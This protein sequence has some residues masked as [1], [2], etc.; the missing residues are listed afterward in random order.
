[1]WFALTLALGLALLAVAQQAVYQQCGGIGWTGGT[2]C[3]SGSVCTV[4]N[5]YYSQCLPG[6]APPSSSSSTLPASSSSSPTSTSPTS[7]TSGSAPSS[8]PPANLSPAWQA[9]YT[10]ARAKLTGVSLQD[11][12]SLATGVGWMNG[13]NAASASTKTYPYLDSPRKLR[14]EYSKYFVHKLPWLVSTSPLGVRFGDLVSVFPAGINTAATFNRTLMRQRGAALGTEFHGKGVHVALGPAMNLARAPAAGRNWEG[15]GGDPYLSGEGAFETVTGI[16]SVGVQACAKHLINNEQEHFR[17]TSSSNVDDRTQHE[18]YA[19]PFLRSI[20]AGVASVMCS[21]INGSFACENDKVLNG[22]I[23]GEF[24]FPGYI[25]SDWAATHSTGSV[26]QGLDMTMPGDITFSSGTTYFGQNLVNA[27]QSGSVPQS[28][29]DDMATRI[30]AAWY[31]LGQDSGYPAVNFNSWNVNGPGSTHVNVQGNHK[32][33]IRTIG[34]ASTVLLKNTGK[35]LPLNKPRT[36]GIIGNGA[37][38]GSG[39]A[40]Y[41]YLI[42]PL[43]AI[44]S[45]ASTDGSTVSSSLSD[46]DLNAAGTTATGKDVALVF[47]AA[48]SGEGYITVEGNAG[49]RNDLKAWHSG[50]ALVARVAGANANTIVV[51]NSVGP[52]EVEAWINHPNVTAVVWS[53]LPGQEAGNALVDVLYGAYNPSGRLPYT[54]GKSINDYSAKVIYNSNA[55]ILPIPYSEGLFIDYRHFDQANIAPRFEFGFGLSY[56]TFSYASLS[57][58]GSIGTG[59]APTGPG[60]SLDPWL[61]EK[62]IT[63]TFSLTNSGSVAGHEIPQLYITLPASAQSAPLSLKG[64]DSIFLAPNQS[65]TVTIQLSRFDLSIWNVAAQRWQI[66]SG[67]IGVSVG[68]SSR[69]IRLTGTI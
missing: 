50:D 45:R 44:T 38:W 68:A 6:T 47:I 31:L 3:A 49:D 28:R 52:I 33:L 56:T 26:N 7:T 57:I 41:P 24:G 25:M 63:V 51:V 32:D 42:T 34:A 65:K 1:M 46:T 13:E 19:L 29:I 5:D 37:G 58:S 16:Q 36:I 48:N 2:T 23:K 8:T 30:L 69:D 22:I 60:S 59:T 35:A 66:P 21:Y 27:V 18:L 20:Q 15:F 43:A 14:G 67:S 10:K 9:A 40:D 11:K 61:H 17:E 12:V 54:I 55:N 4:L 53:G 62:V 39:T 64:F